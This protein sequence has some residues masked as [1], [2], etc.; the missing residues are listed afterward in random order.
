MESINYVLALDFVG[1]FVFAISGA[2]TAAKQ[3]F[4]LMG[5]SII[6][7]VTALGG[8]TVRDVLLGI[9]PV[10]WMVNIEYLFIIAGGVLITF[11]F[12]KKLE[13]IRKTLFLFDAMGLGVFAISGLET[14][15]ALGIHPVYAILL[16]M[17][18]GTMGGVIRDI[19]CNVTPL[20]FRREIYASAGI[21]G[22]SAYYL[23]KT[24]AEFPP[25]ATFLISVVLVISIRIAAVRFKLGLPRIS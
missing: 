7:F 10:G 3:R 24:H 8:G 6:A 12:H 19:L 11:F 2:L 14:S 1:T 17:I 16:G 20:I 25:S 13:H 9:E 5:V 22:A 15:L 18:S 21:I 4:D 23:L